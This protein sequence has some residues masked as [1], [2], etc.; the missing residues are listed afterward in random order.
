MRGFS[1]S[2]ANLVVVAKTNPD[3]VLPQRQTEGSAGFDLFY[4]MV[5]RHE[6]PAGKTSLVMLGIRFVI[7][8]GY[9]GQVRARSSMARDG[10]VVPNAPGTIDADYR[11]ELGVL[12]MNTT[13]RLY[14]IYPGARIA[15]LVIA[16]VARVGLIE[17]VGD[18]AAFMKAYGNTARGT[19]GFGST[20]K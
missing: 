5:P 19:G 13:D 11:G 16:P 3:A 2:P 17:F 12:L 15:Q 18:E 8:S 20:G 9:E 7:P 6:I 1:H 14:V 10:I 4:P